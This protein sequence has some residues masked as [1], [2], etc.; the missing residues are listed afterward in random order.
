[1]IGIFAALGA[2]YA[3]TFASF[4]FREQTKYFSAS[5]L[6]LIK[7]LIAFLIFFPALFTIDIFSNYKNIIILII[8]GF[9]GIAVGDTFFLSALK[10]IGTRKTLTIEA[11]S[12]ILANILG[13]LLINESISL[14]AWI[15]TLIVTLSLI[16]I[17]IYKTVDKNYD[18]RLKT[19]YGFL[20]AI[21]SVLCTVLAAILARL[22]LANSDLNP[23]QSSEL[24][25][26]GSL[27]ILI[28]FV[29]IDFR[30]IKNNV[31]KKSKVKLLLASF[32]GTNIELFLQQTV[33][34]F[35]TVG[36]GWT[37]LSCA[38]AMSLLFAKAEGEK[39][40]IFTIFLTFLTILGVLIVLNA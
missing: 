19:N 20:Y 14:K 18:Q 15:G 7:S 34:K 8:S 39:M 13:S 2:A 36:L 5:Q 17:S 1:M 22:V 25:L 12:P 10:R 38:P 26:M 21:I 30:K 27:I 4:L 37:L 11:L 35:L 40:N 6:N 33:F 24:R 9:L 32:L 29:R 31:P 23:L 16:G 3:G 28:P